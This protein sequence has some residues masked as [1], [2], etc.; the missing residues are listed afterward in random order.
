[1][2]QIQELSVELWSFG[3][4]EDVLSTAVVGFP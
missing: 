1:M 4:I 3:A 2:N